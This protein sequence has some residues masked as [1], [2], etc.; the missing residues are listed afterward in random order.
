MDEIDRFLEEAGP[1]AE[2]FREFAEAAKKVPPMTEEEDARM[3]REF[4]ARL[5][6]LLRTRKEQRRLAF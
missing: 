5:D 4:H 1:A 6:E 3:E 2:G